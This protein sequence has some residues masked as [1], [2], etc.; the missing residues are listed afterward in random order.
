MPSG[1]V[2]PTNVLKATVEE[3]RAC[4]FSYAKANYIHNVA[5]HSKLTQ[6]IFCSIS[7][8]M[9]KSSSC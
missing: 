2:T 3:M 9:K 5:K 6:I 4:G 8:M 1:K 7:S